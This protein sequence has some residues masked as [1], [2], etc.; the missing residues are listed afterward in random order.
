MDYGFWISDFLPRGVKKVAKRILDYGFRIFESGFWI[1]L[2][3]LSIGS[4]FARNSKVI[5]TNTT[6]VARNGVLVR[7]PSLAQNLKV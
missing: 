1:G 2:Q 3:N 6:Y 4:A 5:A 7:T